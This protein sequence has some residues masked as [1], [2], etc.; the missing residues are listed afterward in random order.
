MCTVAELGL[1][2]RLERRWGTRVD[3]EGRQRDVTK[4]RNVVGEEEGGEKK[5]G[6]K[7]EDVRTR[8]LQRG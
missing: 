3:V 5:T 4:R 6:C 1:R 2:L 8:Q 7:V